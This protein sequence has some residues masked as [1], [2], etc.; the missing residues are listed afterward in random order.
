[1][2]KKSVSVD[3]VRNPDLT[4]R[5]FEWISYF[6]SYYFWFYSLYVTYFTGEDT[7]K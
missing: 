1:M 7:D 5:L 4:E 3:S 6:S 2:K